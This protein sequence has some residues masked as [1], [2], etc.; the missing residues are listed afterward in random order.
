MHDYNNYIKDMIN[1]IENINSY[2]E[3]CGGIDK[4][5]SNKMAF[6]AILRNLEIVGEGANIAKKEFNEKY[7]DIPWK[8]IAD[9]RIIVAHKYFGIDRKIVY[10]ILINHLPQLQEQLKE[11]ISNK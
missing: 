3:Q 9:F 7:P 11:I 1:A 2:L 4:L 6:D 10:D 8:K 5:E